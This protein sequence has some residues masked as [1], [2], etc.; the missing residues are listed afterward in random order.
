MRKKL[1][2]L[3]LIISSLIALGSFFNVQN[4]III[5]YQEGDKEIRTVL[6]QAEVLGIMFE[7]SKAQIY[8][9]QEVLTQPPKVKFWIESEDV[10]INYS[11]WELPTKM[12]IFNENNRQFFKIYFDES[13]YLYR[14]F[15][16]R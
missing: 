13:D 10:R 1:L 4:N 9:D 16:S 6:K 3:L 5:R 14:Y 2:F 8:E 11:I 7:L 12:I 15:G